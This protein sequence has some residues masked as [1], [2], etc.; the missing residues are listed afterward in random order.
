MSQMD[1]Y[2]EA[3]VRVHVHIDSG[4][5]V[6]CKG[7]EL[8]VVRGKGDIKK[9]LLPVSKILYTFDQLK[10]AGAKCDVVTLSSLA[11]AGAEGRWRNEID[12]RKRD[13][14]PSNVYVA[15]ARSV[16]LALAAGKTPPPVRWVGRQ[17]NRI[18]EVYDTIDEVVA[19]MGEERWRT[20][21]KRGR[22]AKKGPK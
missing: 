16:E 14:I 9:V 7:E 6:W 4:Q 21:F 20:D 1:P 17:S 18:T 13:G 19:A 11:R 8:G 15:N 10:R 2:V 22:Y 5:R 12:D 3:F